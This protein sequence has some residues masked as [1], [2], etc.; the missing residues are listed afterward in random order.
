MRE[1]KGDSQIQETAKIHD[2]DFKQEF[3]FSVKVKL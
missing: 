2:P 1:R 3:K